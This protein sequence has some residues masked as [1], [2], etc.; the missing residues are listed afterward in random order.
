ME[1]RPFHPLK[2]AHHSLS[3][4]RLILTPSAYKFHLS[5]HFSEAAKSAFPPER[6]KCDPQSRTTEQGGR[7]AY[8][9]ALNVSVL[10]NGQFKVVLGGGGWEAVLGQFCCASSKQLMHSW[11][12]ASDLTA[13]SS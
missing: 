4:Q 9:E 3:S 1:G 2:L 7:F 5:T 12:M 13:F 11:E 8:K 10:R 6:G